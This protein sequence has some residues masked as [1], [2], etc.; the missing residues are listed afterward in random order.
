MRS[1]RLR[2][3]YSDDGTGII[4]HR[5]MFI[6]DSALMHLATGD[7]PP[8]SYVSN[9]DITTVVEGIREH[10]SLDDIILVDTGPLACVVTSLTGRATTNGMFKEVAPPETSYR[11]LPPLRAYLVR[12]RIEGTDPSHTVVAT[13]TLSLVVRDDDAMYASRSVLSASVPYAVAYAFVCLW[14][15]ITIHDAW[16]KKT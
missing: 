13:E 8:Q 16:R 6:Q 1:R 9:S 5:R 2:G 12:F 4:K 7:L 10:T 14:A 11:K 15:I 3:G